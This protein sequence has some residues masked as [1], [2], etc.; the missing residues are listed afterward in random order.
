M[1]TEEVGADAENAEKS[2]TEVE[3]NEE[4]SSHIDEAEKVQADIEE[5]VA[6][7]V[8]ADGLA[9]LEGLAASGLRSVRFCKEIPGISRVVANDCSREAIATMKHNIE[10]N[11]VQE[12]MSASCNDA[13]MVMHLAAKSHKDLYDVIDLD[14][15]GGPTQFLDGA[16]KAVNHGGLLCVTCTDMAI[17]C[18]N[19]SEKCFAA[20][21]AMSVKTKSCHEVALRIVLRAIDGFANRYGK[22]I[23]PLLSVSVDFYCRVFVRV[24]AG[25]RKAKESASKS[26]MLYECSGCG[27]HHFQPLGECARLTLFVNHYCCLRS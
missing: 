12:M 22:Y 23:V 24:F 27:A 9:I 18:G 5:R 17:L 19:A 16:V 25:P 4:I 26:A 15:Y 20:Y 7:T 14:P 3:R 8:Y 13:S 10:L 11:G 2:N 21:G 6:G 1:D